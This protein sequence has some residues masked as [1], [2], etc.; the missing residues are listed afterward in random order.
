[1]TN[2]E[3]MEQFQFIDGVQKAQMLA[4]RALLRQAP[5]VQTQLQKYAAVLGEQEFFLELDAIQ[6]EAMMQHLNDLVR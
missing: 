5:D 1:M 2:T 3:I 4:L 6:Q